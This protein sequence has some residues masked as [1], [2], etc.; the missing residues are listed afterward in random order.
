MT[1]TAPLNEPY[2]VTDVDSESD[3]ISV[4]IAIDQTIEFMVTDHTNKG[5]KKFSSMTASQAIDFGH[6]I[7]SAAEALRDITRHT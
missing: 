5:T 6:A 1:H 7:I 3:S 2:S 4:C